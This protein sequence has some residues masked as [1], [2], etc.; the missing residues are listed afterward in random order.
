MEIFNFPLPSPIVIA[1]QRMEKASRDVAEVAR[2]VAEN[3]V[4][5]LAENATDL[6]LAE[7]V[8]RANAAVVRVADDMQSQLLDITA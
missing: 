3:G 4:E 5:N 7:T 1:L 8:F 2:D 6:K